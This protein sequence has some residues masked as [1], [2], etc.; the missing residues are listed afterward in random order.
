MLVPE[1][2]G[3]C[4][5]SGQ[6]PLDLCRRA[7]LSIALPDPSHLPAQGLPQ[8]ATFWFLEGAEE[9]NDGSRVITF[10][11]QFDL[12]FQKI[13]RR[14]L[15][16]SVCCFLIQPINVILAQKKPQRLKE[17]ISGWAGYR[18]KTS[19]FKRLIT[20]PAKMSQRQ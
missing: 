15:T 9:P 2:H 3:H 7:P 1:V 6:V 8:V 19:R 13:Y 10:R 11:F 12:M 5:S 4:R 14:G 16:A 18:L 20:K 17:L